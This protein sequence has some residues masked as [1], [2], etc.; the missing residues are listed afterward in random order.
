MSIRWSVIGKRLTLIGKSLGTYALGIVVSAGFALPPTAAVWLTPLIRNEALRRQIREW[1]G[2]SLFVIGTN[3]PHYDP[4]LVEEVR[5]S[6]GGEVVTI[7]GADH[8]LEIAG[9]LPGSV[10]AVERVLVAMES[11]LDGLA[12]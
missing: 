3:D 2:P 9:D 4:D 10:R 1:G 11:F 12:T 5:E 7:D 8:I 6:T